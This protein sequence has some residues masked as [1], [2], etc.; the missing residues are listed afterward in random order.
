MAPCGATPSIRLLREEDCVERNSFS[1]S[2]AQNRLNEDLTRS[3]RIT[4]YGL[5]G[6]SANET[7]TDCGSEAA[8]S[9]RK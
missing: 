2:H 9:G 7:Y 3:F 1:E 4:T 6:F 5:D 8:N